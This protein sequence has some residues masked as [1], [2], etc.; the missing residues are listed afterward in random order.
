[1][2]VASGLFSSWATPEIVWPERG[3]L[4]GLQQLVIDVA[5]F[6]VEL[7]ALADVAHERLEPQAL[8]VGWRIGA[9]R[10][11]HPHRVAVG[12]AQA[13]QVIVDRS[14]GRQ[15]LDERDARPGDR[16]NDRDRT[17]GRR[18]RALRLRGRISA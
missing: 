6:V 17:A 11:L 16:R 14:V 4:L 10:H 2:I 12:A 1:M 15:P 3:H 9:R 18:F 5:G 8:I 7:L 13:Q